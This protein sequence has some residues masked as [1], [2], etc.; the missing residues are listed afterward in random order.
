MNFTKTFPALALSVLFFH[1]N[2]QA[3]EI[4]ILNDETHLDVRRIVSVRL[5]GMIEKKVLEEITWR[6]WREQPL[7]GATYVHFHLP[8]TEIGDAWAYTI[9]ERRAD[10]PMRVLVKD[11]TG[12]F[13]LQ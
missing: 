3:Q 13:R 11:S 10:Q 12:I 6:L 7:I 1:G 4:E 2:A 5:D 8:G 9:Y